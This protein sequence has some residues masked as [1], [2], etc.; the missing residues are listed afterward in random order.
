MASTI[1]FADVPPGYPKLASLISKDKNYAVFRKFSSLNARNI[2]YLQSELTELESQLEQI[3]QDLRL[4][5]EK[6]LR[7]REDFCSDPDRS[8]L[9]RK[10]RRTLHLYSMSHCFLHTAISQQIS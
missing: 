4:T 8:L 3:D 10:I 1:R 5:G 9:I 2:L 7:S 6:C